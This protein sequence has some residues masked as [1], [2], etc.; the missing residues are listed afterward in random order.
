MLA[1]VLTLISSTQAVS[2]GSID[3]DYNPS[4]QVTCD[5]ISDPQPVRFSYSDT[6]G[7]GGG[8]R[9]HFPYNSDKCVGDSAGSVVDVAPPYVPPEGVVFAS[10]VVTYYHNDALGSPVAATNGKGEVL[11]S[12]EYRPYG[13]RLLKQDEGTNEEWF[14]GKPHEEEIGLSYFGARWYDPESGRFMGV[15]PVGVDA[16]KPMAFNRYIYANNN[17]YR[18]IDPDGKEALEIFTKRLVT[19]G[20]SSQTDSPAPGPGDVIAVGI[21][22]YGTGEL[23]VNAYN[24]S[25]ESPDKS[26]ITDDQGSDTTNGLEDEKDSDDNAR[27]KGDRFTSGDDALG[28]LEEIE[29]AQRNVRRGRSGQI[30][31]SIEKSKQRA[32][33]SLKP[34]NI[35]LD[36]L[37]DF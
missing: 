15:D 25:Q 4:E 12:E 30:I 7:S 24:E 33:N 10:S 13:A 36:N 22:L 5:Y 18:Y 1:L 8:G 14:T 23:I 3:F 20:I 16:Q 9:V 11:W 6:S 21:L 19:A 37:D 28:Q 31:D 2:G 34:H 29:K 17:P 27:Q 26:P 32:N 35:D